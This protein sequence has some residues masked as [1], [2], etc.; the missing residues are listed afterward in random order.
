MP[1]GSVYLL[2]VNHRFVSEYSN[3]KG[4]AGNMINNMIYGALEIETNQLLKNKS[5]S[6]ERYLIYTV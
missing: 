6:A 2:G 1:G 5:S 4:R 3:F